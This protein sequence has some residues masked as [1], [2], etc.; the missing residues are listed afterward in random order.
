[1]GQ[2]TL[3]IE[4]GANGLQ[5][6]TSGDRIHGRVILE[7]DEDIK[8]DGVRVQLCGTE[9]SFWTSDLTGF[10]GDAY[11]EVYDV[12][13]SGIQLAG[14]PPPSLMTRLIETAKSNSQRLQ[15]KRGRHVWPFS[16][17]LPLHLPPSYKSKR[18]SEIAYSLKAIIEGMNPDLV[19]MKV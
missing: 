17:D 1:M 6:W 4:P 12:M 2:L 8:A 19:A 16:I 15:L 18:G 11:S 7:L 5:E 10:I 14:V 9:T 13:E 3:E